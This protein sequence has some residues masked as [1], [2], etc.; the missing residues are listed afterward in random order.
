MS[1]DPE[2]ERHN[3]NLNTKNEPRHEIAKGPGVQIE[4][5]DKCKNAL[6]H[7]GLHC[8]LRL[9]AVCL[10][11]LKYI[12]NL[13]IHKY[14]KR[15]SFGKQVLISSIILRAPDIYSR[16]IMPLAPSNRIMVSMGLKF[17]SFGTRSEVLT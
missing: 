14:T 1:P 9:F 11:G 8:V 13:E 5:T 2:G 4:Y 16:R 7:Q 15:E 17:T 12:W 6:F 10:R 3:N